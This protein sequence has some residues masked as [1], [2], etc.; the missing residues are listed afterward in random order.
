MD[1]KKF[2]FSFNFHYICNGIQIQIGHLSEIRLLL[3]YDGL[4][5]FFVSILLRVFSFRILKVFYYICDILQ[6]EIFNL[7]ESLLLFVYQTLEFFF[8]GIE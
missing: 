3:V 7:S 4:D 8:V 1:L 2:I 5:F 6:V